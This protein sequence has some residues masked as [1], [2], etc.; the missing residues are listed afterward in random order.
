M[1]TTTHQRAEST[2]PVRAVTVRRPGEGDAVWFLDNFIVVKASGRDGARL[3]LIE[4]LLPPGSETPFHRHHDEDESWYVLEGTMTFFF[5][6][7]QRFQAE[8]GAFVHVPRGVAHGFRTKT[9]VKMLVLC[10]PDGFVE[11]ARDYGVEAPRRE[12]PPMV[13]PDLPRLAEVAENHRI[14]ILGPLPA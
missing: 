6:G 3:G 4:N 10:A 2:S 1:P 9:A 13:P 8:P 12:P 5:E 7:G 14:Q 11:I